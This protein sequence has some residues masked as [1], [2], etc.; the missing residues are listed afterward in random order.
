MSG[1]GAEA[2]AML[3]GVSMSL[4]GRW[5]QAG[6]DEGLTPPQAMSLMSLSVDEPR[7]I[8]D[9][10]R[11][12]HCDASYATAL[13]DRLEERGFAERRTSATDRR[14]KELVPTREGIAAQ[15]RL[16]AAFTAP[17]PGLEELPAGDQE[18][19][20]RVARALAEH[21]DPE[22][23]ARFGLAPREGPPG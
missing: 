22:M 6:L 3:V 18:A 14:V 4:R 10:A 17:P 8:G 13:A 12:M 20:L 9:L 21:I 11:Y 19:M 15:A 23:A 1:P 16:R 2:W 7:R 5:L